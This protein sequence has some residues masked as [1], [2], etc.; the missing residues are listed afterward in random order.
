MERL[1]YRCAVR[2]LVADDNADLRALL[3]V[4][5]ELDG[6]FEVVAETADCTSTLAVAEVL[7]PDVVLVDLRMPGD[8][9]D[10][11]A[12]LCAADLPVVVLTGWLVDEDRERVLANGASAFLVKAPDLLAALVPAL[13]SAVPVR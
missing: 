2:V 6:G 7:R 5:L 13:R 9:V 10:L 12:R 3:R 4:S 1:P 11:V 8:S